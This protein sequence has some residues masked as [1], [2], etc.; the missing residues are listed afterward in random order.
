VDKDVAKRKKEIFNKRI[1]GGK[2]ENASADLPEKCQRTI[3]R[4]ENV[5]FESLPK[6]GSPRTPPKGPCRKLPPRR[7]V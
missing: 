4:E 3:R 5:L 2:R 1:V 7:K 6:G